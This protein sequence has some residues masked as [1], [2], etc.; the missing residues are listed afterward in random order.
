MQI[1]AKTTLLTI[2][3]S[4]FRAVVFSA[5]IAVCAL[6]ATPL[7][8]Q[9]ATIEGKTVA[10]VRVVDGF[11]KAVSEKIPPLPLEAGKP[12]DYSAERESLRILYRM[13]DF[14]SI[15]VNSVPE[16]SGLRIDFVVERNF[17][18]NVIRIEG[19]KEPPSAPAALAALRLSLGEPFRESALREAV[20]RL[21]S[22]LSDDG[23]YEA[24][25]TWSLNPHDDTREMDVI[26]TVDPGPRAR[27]GNVHLENETSYTDAQLLKRSKIS[28]KSAVTSAGLSHAA[29][30]VKKYLVKQGYLG[31]GARFERGTYDPQAKQVPLTLSVTAGPRVRMEIVGA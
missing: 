25:I 19:L 10:E 14:A 22:S 11:G 12:F 13:G 29:D 2:P 21:Q 27:V 23:L 26:F 9:E 30:R 4:I 3:R 6:A 20:A 28:M 1:L 17:Y 24:K 5:W 18:N 16:T 15:D 8:A 31:A 7:A